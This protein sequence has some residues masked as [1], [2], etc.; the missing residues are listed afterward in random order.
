LK[1]SALADGHKA[2]PAFLKPILVIVCPTVEV[3]CPI[4]DAPSTFVEIINGI[5]LVG[6]R[7]V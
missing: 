1:P 7:I 3:V 5:P 2:I 6:Y 4:V